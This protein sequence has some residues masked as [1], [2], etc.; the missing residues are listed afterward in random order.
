M[1]DVV[2]VSRN[3]RMG[4]FACCSAPGDVLLT[5]GLGSCIGLVLLDQRTTVAGLAHIVLPGPRVSST[6]EPGKF[7]DYAVPA[8]IAQAVGI[9]ANRSSLEAVL[10]GGASMFAFNAPGLSSMDVGQRNAEVVR[11]ELEQARIPVR[12][13]S[14][15]GT[16]GRTV[17]VHVADRTVMVKEAGGPEL[18]LWTGRPVSARPRRGV[19]A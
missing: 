11:A 14:T 4:E 2:V 15:G 9:G 7:A 8:L 5:I 1:D 17:R 13:A 6:R 16:K 3:V 10:V 19:P 18:E 12:E